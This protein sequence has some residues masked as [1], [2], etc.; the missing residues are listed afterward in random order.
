MADRDALT[1]ESLRAEV[2]GWLADNWDAELPLMHWRRRLVDAGWAAPSWP[3]RWHGRGLPAWTDAVV[4]DELIDGGA[5][6]APVG[7]AM[8]LAGPTI[9]EQG[10]DP[11]R[12]RFLEPILT[13]EETWCQ[14][15][16]EPG[17]GSDLAGLQTTAVRDGD[18]WVVNGQ[19]VWTTSAHHADLGMLLARTDPTAP[20]HSGITYFALPMKQDG[21][22]VRPLRQM[23]WHQSFNEVFLTD[24]RVPHENVIGEV[25][26]GWTAARTT[27]AHERR[28]GRQRPPNYS[29]P[30]AG[31]STRPATRPT[32]T[33]PSTAG[34]RSAP[35]APT[36]SSPTPAPA[37]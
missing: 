32:S 21:V 37:A 6:G 3:K 1:P 27:L 25:G 29:A 9:L 30:P 17:A 11:V 7:G 14:L 15:F 19:K 5:V 20:K 16:S 4:T 2:S 36:S 31:R 26:G 33:S 23:N 8:S 35:V 24:A 12:E 13:G 34:I 10:P 18:D 28:L 22:V